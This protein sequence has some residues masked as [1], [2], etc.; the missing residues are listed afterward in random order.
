MLMTKFTVLHLAFFKT[1]PE[2]GLCGGAMVTELFAG[3][4]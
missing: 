1:C 4:F 3:R 2:G